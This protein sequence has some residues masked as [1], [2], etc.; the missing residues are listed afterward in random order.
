MVTCEVLFAEYLKCAVEQVVTLAVTARVM[1]VHAEVPL[2]ERHVNVI[3]TERCLFDLQSCQ[4]RLQLAS[5]ARNSQVY[6]R[7]VA[8]PR[9]FDLWRSSAAQCD[10]ALSHDSH[11]SPLSIRSDHRAHDLLKIDLATH[12]DA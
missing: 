12:R 7:C 1:F 6:S 11:V 10:A 5:M 3:V 9:R 2:N 8:W 4:L